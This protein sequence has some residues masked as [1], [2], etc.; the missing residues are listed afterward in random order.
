[1]KNESEGIMMAVLVADFKIQWQHLLLGYVILRAGSE[2][3]Y[4]RL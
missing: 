1:M 2:P 4:F 3:S